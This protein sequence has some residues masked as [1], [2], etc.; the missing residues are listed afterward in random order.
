MTGF[1][2][3]VGSAVVNE[4]TLASDMFAMLAMLHEGVDHVCA[5]RSVILGLQY[6]TFG[7]GQCFALVSIVLG[8]P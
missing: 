3:T 1:A 6:S 7:D 2:E 8:L 5:S 4:N